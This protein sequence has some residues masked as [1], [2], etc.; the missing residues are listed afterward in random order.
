YVA[1]TLFAD[2]THAM[3]VVREEIFGPVVAVVP[4]DDE[5]EGIALAN[6]SDYGLLDYVWS[7]DVAGPGSIF[8]VS[9]RR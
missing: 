1:P 3:R 9:R 7:G 8:S 5:E 4:F 6:D 2:C